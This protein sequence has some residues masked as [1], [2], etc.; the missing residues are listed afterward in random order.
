MFI[1]SNISFLKVQEYFNRISSLTPLSKNRRMVFRF[2]EGLYDLGL[3]K[4][5][6]CWFLTTDKNVGIS[7]TVYSIGGLGYTEHPCGYAQEEQLGYFDAFANNVSWNLCGANFFGNPTSFI[8]TTLNPL[9]AGFSPT[10][11]SLIVEVIDPQYRPSTTEYGTIGAY[12]S[13]QAKLGLD[14]SEIGPVRF[15]SSYK[16]ETLTTE[17]SGS[18]GFWVASRTAADEVFIHRNGIAQSII[19]NTTP[20]PHPILDVLPNR[21]LYI[22]GCNSQRTYSTASCGFL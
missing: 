10:N 1:T 22:G 20:T 16:Y 3:W 8:D 12:E 7:P 19:T 6:A 13:Q 18:P 17:I 4:D 9:S 11:V 15:S 21:N 14:I 2:V 5:V